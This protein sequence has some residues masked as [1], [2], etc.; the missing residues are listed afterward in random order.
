MSE[1]A[2][3]PP[4]RH[5]AT[6]R[7][8]VSEVVMPA[9]IAPRAHSATTVLVHRIPNGDARCASEAHRNARALSMQ[10]QPLSHR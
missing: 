8:H 10:T 1:S 7:D 9:W 4:L 2:V 6:R 5:S 3:G